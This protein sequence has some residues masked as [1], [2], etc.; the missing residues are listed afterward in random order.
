MTYLP[1]PPPKKKSNTGLLVALIGGAAALCLVLGV[2]G[3]V[4]YATRDRH[5]DST[6]GALN[7]PVRDVHTQF[8]VTAVQ[9]GVTGL[10]TEPAAG[11][12]YCTAT[13]TV[14]NVGERPIAIEVQSQ[15]AFDQKG[16]KFLANSTASISANDDIT[17]FGEQ[18]EPGTGATVTWV[19]E[20]PV[21]STIERLELHQILQSDGAEV[22]V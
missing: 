12:T 8:T 19:W 2:V 11:T 3:T 6:D 5:P 16:H 20:L 13:A 10:R 21:G 4:L 1:W 9:C 14:K 17:I 15:A 22:T 18:Y 7:Q